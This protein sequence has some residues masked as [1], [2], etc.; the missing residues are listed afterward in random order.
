MVNFL[1]KMKKRHLYILNCQLSAVLRNLFLCLALITMKEKELK[2]TLV[3]QS[4]GLPLRVLKLAV[5]V[6]KH[7][8][9]M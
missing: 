6:H 5:Q 1:I 8:L 3:K 4:V 9:Y 2:K 7:Y